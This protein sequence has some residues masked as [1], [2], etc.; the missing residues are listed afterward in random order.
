MI[1]KNRYVF[2]ARN[3]HCVV[4]YAVRYLVREY[5]EGVHAPELRGDSVHRLVENSQF[6]PRTFG[7]S[8][9]VSVEPIHPTNQGNAHAI[10][11]AFFSVSAGA[12]ESFA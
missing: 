11:L 6:Y 10:I 12:S 7:F 4:F 1:E 5:H 9:V 8:G 3:A 2:R